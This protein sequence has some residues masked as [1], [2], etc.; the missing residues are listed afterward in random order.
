MQKEDINIQ[1]AFPFVFIILI[2]ID[3]ISKVSDQVV[4]TGLIKMDVEELVLE[5]ESIGAIKVREYF[6]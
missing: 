2:C 6:F 3:I 1:S 4:N 5:L